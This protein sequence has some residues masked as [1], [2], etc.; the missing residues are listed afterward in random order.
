MPK[1]TLRASANALP[2]SDPHP[3]A[4][5]FALAQK[6]KESA[7]LR[8]KLGEV[9]GAAE[10]KLASLRAIRPQLVGAIAEEADRVLAEEEAGI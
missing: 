6:L 9:F 10:A 7:L 8:D 4:E 5:V 1:R 3:D 2:K